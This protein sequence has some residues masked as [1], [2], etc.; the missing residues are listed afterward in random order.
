[1]T[2]RFDAAREVLENDALPPQQLAAPFVDA[3]AISGAAVSTLGDLLGS[4]TVSATDEDAARLDEV[5]FDLGEGPCWDAVRT[6]APVLTPQLRGSEAQLRWPA[7]IRAV[8]QHDVGSVFAFPLAIGH[9]RFGAIDLY[10]ARPMS[11]DRSQTAQA[12]ILAEIVGRAVWRRALAAL[13]TGQEN[14]DTLHSRRV[15]H[16]ATGVVL[17]QLDLT[18]DEALLVL[19]GH[20]FAA[21]RSVRSVAEEVLA[22]TLTFTRDDGVIEVRR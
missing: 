10:S 2:D 3:F 22:K 9:M 21:G 6:A 5:Q 13:E 15:I 18:A 12:S 14:D 7:F 11:L 16:Q 4:E 8:A 1:M 19:K 17:A 20:A